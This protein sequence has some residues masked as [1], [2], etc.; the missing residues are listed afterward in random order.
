MK[1]SVS[2]I[3]QKFLSDL[4]K[5]SHGVRWLVFTVSL[6]GCLSVMMSLLFIW[7]IKSIIDMAVSPGH[8]ISKISIAG[9]IGCLLLQLLIPAIRRR[10]E[11]IA[12][13]KYSNTLRKKLLNH[14]LLSKWSG[15]RDMH[16][17]DAIN[18]IQ[19]DVDMLAGLTC[20]NFPGLAAVLLQLAG[21]LFF[22]IIL[23]ARLAVVLVFIMPF[24]LLTSKI[25]IKRTK[26]LTSEIRKD[27]SNMQTFLQEKLHHR[28]LLSTLMSS[29][30]IL[31]KFNVRQSSLSDKIIRRTDISIFSSMAVTA[32]FMT[33]YAVTF[34]WSVYGLTTGMISFGMMTAFLQLVG[35]VQRPAVDL[36]Q[37]LPAFINAA[38]S[39]ER[40][41]DITSVPLEDFSSPDL[42]RRHS[43]G[44]RLSDVSYSYPDNEDRK[45]VE[46][47]SHDFKPGSIT[48]IIGPTGVGKTTLVRLL[49][50]HV[51]PTSGKASAYCDYNREYKI[52]AGIR[53]NTVYVPQGNTLMYGTIREN[54]LLGN[55]S[56]TEDMMMEA[57][58]TA[59][60]DFIMELPKGI[61]SDC[62][63]GGIGLSE[64]QAHRIAIA[65]GL[66]KSGNIFIFDE[67]TSALD[68]STEKELMT[69]LIQNLPTSST[70][71]IVTHRLEVLKFCT[72]ILELT[73]PEKC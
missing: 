39:I 58:H 24:A 69:R 54:L 59:A 1:I 19:K 63:E 33:G 41:G 22:I 34:L 73:I 49:L 12:I 9:L 66:L 57:I 72:D 68:E 10:I 46:H 71:I 42:S 26:R 32:G 11:V 2:R 23:D 25:Y 3:Y 4:W 7:I 21:S 70:V 13:M 44:L 17:G 30:K 64:G 47:L 16:T 45:V 28:T 60:A 56:A 53:N 15:R 43:V 51:E 52:G 48:G 50:G 20:S 67:P 18:R 36:S 29:K 61:D 31:E 35:Q 37:R 62:F 6:L 14:L 8:N 27:E 40:V 38:V 5:E 55:P 65:R